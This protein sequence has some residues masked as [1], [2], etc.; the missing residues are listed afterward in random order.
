MLY[1]FDEVDKMDDD[2]PESMISLLSE[3]RIAKIQR[4][5][6]PLKKKASA[7]A[8]LLL[9]LALLEIYGIEKTVEFEYN[10]KG[11]PILRDYSHIYFNLSHSKRTVACAVSNAEVGVDVQHI[12]PISD[13][14]AKRVL[15][16]IEYNAF[17]D[18]KTPDKFFCEIWAIKESFLKKTGQGITSDLRDLTAETVTDKVIFEGKDYFCCACGS[19]MKIRHIGRGDFEQLYN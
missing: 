5:H 2:I 11:K 9:R 4:L 18:S 10:E 3:A 16:E 13:Q 7:A 15:T 6:S 1:I 19:D 14:V 12:S 8:Y 17:K